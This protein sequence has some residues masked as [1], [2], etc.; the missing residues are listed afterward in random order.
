MYAQKES[1]AALALK[2]HPQFL[3]N[4]LLISLDCNKF[5]QISIVVKMLKSMSVHFCHIST[6]LKFRTH[7]VFVFQFFSWKK[8]GKWSREILRPESSIDLIS[9]KIQILGGNFFKNPGFKSPSGKVNFFVPFSFSFHFHI[10]YKKLH[11]FLFNHFLI[12]CFTNQ[13]SIKTNISEFSV[14]VEPT[15]FVNIA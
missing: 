3:E 11:T 4:K 8:N 9:L 14:S 6:A 1:N 7:S 13:L 12:S 5:F 15:I 2:N 10:N